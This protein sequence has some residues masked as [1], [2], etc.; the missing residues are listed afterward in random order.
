[1]E[2]KAINIE[3]KF[4]KENNSIEGIASKYGNKDHVG[5]V[6][7]YG[8]F[9]RSLK[10]RKPKML[11]QHR[12]DMPIGVWDELKETDEGLYVKGRFSD[13]QAGR[14]A[15]ELAKDG[16]IDSMSIGYA[17]VKSEYDE[18]NSLRKLVDV[19]LYE[20]SLVTFPANDKATITSVKADSI[21]DIRDF[22]DHLREVGFSNYKAKLIAV[23]G[24]KG[25]S[26]DSRDD[27]IC[28]LKK[29]INHTINILK[30]I[31]TCL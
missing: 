9:S 24:F 8:A 1:M 25:T 2:Q 14:E 30:G 13:T 19:D 11:W 10:E 26:N 29:S 4:N 5:D 20:I 28:E 16:A 21:K 27:S 3:L 6:V 22:E 15:R 7:V 31:D 18:V 17:T 12:T 23:N